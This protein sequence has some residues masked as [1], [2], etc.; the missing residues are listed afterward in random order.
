MRR[1]AFI[2]VVSLVIIFLTGCPK[3]DIHYS[4]SG[5]VRPYSGE[6]GFAVQRKGY[7]PELTAKDIER[8]FTDDYVVIFD[9]GYDSTILTGVEVLG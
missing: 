8:G 2:S 7:V 3:V 5:V 6:E 1:Y 4:L 9:S